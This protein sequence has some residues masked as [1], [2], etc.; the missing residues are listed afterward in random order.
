LAYDSPAILLLR[1]LEAATA[2]P[3]S[4][5]NQWVQLTTA[6]DALRSLLE[7]SYVD[8]TDGLAAE[9]ER[10]QATAA[11]DTD[12]L[13]SLVIRIAQLEPLPYATE[14][15]P[16]PCGTTKARYRLRHAYEGNRGF[17]LST[18]EVRSLPVLDDTLTDGRLAPGLIDAYVAAVRLA[19]SQFGVT[20]LA[21]IDKNFG[22]IG[23][24]G[25]VA[26]LTEKT[27]LPAVVHR[28]RKW[29][30]KA[31]FSAFRPDPGEK[32]VIIYDL[33]NTGAAIRAAS[34]RIAE[35]FAAK[36]SAA[37]V[38]FNLSSDVTVVNTLADEPVVILALD[39]VD[40]PSGLLKPD[41]NPPGRE[42]ASLRGVEDS[43][44]F[45]HGEEM[46]KRTGA[47]EG[48][49]EPEYRELLKRILENPRLAREAFPSEELRQKALPLYDSLAALADGPRDG[50]P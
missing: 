44:S 33:V 30:K 47:R 13:I 50:K 48:A 19:Q 31:D 18:G 3:P 9:V 35:E 37:I 40:G 12:A 25:L 43:R 26:A 15:R 49:P 11:E 36:I 28:E 8:W 38:L 34:E 10:V 6:I 20:Y 5:P 7:D 41:I 32:G 46:K 1:Q 17:L 29:S 24:L 21:F 23:A 27:G 16:I 14:L 22:P 2:K 42:L 39:G 45:P 4:S